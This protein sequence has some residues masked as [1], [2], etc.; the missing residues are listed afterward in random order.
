MSA[1]R[2]EREGEVRKRGCRMRDAHKWHTIIGRKL[3]GSCEAAARRPHPKRGT[4][5]LMARSSRRSRP[6]HN[7]RAVSSP[8]LLCLSCAH[9]S[10][11]LRSNRDPPT[12]H[13]C[14]ACAHSY[15]TGTTHHRASLAARSR[16]VDRSHACSRSLCGPLGTIGRRSIASS[17]RASAR[18]SELASIRPF[19]RDALIRLA[20]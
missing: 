15:R 10:S 7:S 11:P 20:S 18:H 14:D 16:R 17:A 1:T 4:R 6:S 19:A 8:P 2:R 9:L 13:A 3:P 5:E 12:I